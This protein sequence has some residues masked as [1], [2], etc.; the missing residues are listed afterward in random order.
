MFTWMLR[1]P[2]V[3][4]IT[5][6]WHRLVS[7]LCTERMGVADVPG[8]HR[9][10][11]KPETT[12]VVVALN[13]PCS[14]DSPANRLWPPNTKT[15][16]RMSADWNK[17]ASLREE[18]PGKG[19]EDRAPK[20]LQ[21]TGTNGGMLEGT[22]HANRGD[23][24]SDNPG[25]QGQN[26]YTSAYGCAKQPRE[27]KHETVIG[28]E[29]S[30]GNACGHIVLPQKNHSEGVENKLKVLWKIAN[31]KILSEL[32]QGQFWGPIMNVTSTKEELTREREGVVDSPVKLN[33]KAAE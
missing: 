24:R 28:K 15:L 20:W 1:S 18:H 7:V 11:Q 10:G 27:N 12:W 14:S 2:K 31:S 3:H 30:K 21:Q 22:M 9:C 4:V 23:C 26:Q 5:Q 29:W 33:P 13:S 16:A 8:L 25:S 6:K 17:N 32:G 19:K